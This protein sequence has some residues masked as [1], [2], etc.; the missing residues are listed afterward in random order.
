MSDEKITLDGK[1]VTK[2]QLQEAQQNPSVRII[3]DKNNKGEFRTLKRE[4]G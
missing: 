1:E 4:R 2:E 3:E